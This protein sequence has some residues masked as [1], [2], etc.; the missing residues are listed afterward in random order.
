MSGETSE[1]QEGPRAG[2]GWLARMARQVWDHFGKPDP[3]R[4]NTPR[5]QEII[6]IYRQAYVKGGLSLP[7]AR[8]VHRIWHRESMTT[9][10]VQLLI[11]LPAGLLG[12]VELSQLVLVPAALW[13]AL[14]YTTIANVL[15]VLVWQLRL[16][17][18]LHASG[19]PV[20]QRSLLGYAAALTVLSLG[21]SG[22]EA[23]F[24]ADI[25]PLA[26]FLPVLLPFQVLLFYI[27]HV[28]YEVHVDYASVTSRWTDTPL[29][30]LLPYDKRGKLVFLRASDHYVIVRTT[31][32]E[33]ELR[34]RF[35]D[36]LGRLGTAR[37]LQ[38]HRSFWVAQ[39]FLTSPRKEGRRM[40]MR[41]DGV[42]IP[43]SATYRDAVARH[44]D[45]ASQ[46]TEG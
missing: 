22:L 18:R 46:S 11:F 27:F 4:L 41:V 40:V 12:A 24:P 33:H 38:V 36:A 7:E 32:G 9:L 5:G 29:Q 2:A 16:Q 19:V 26:Q 1:T 42:I 14:I 25:A 39:D 45:M 23:L 3:N 6:D 20:W 17:P 37:G 34:M 15:F 43:I 21:Y 35:S 10:P 30:R 28:G 13:W 31:K 8:V 44:L